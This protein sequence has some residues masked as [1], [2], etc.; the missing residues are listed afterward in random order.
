MEHENED[1]KGRHIELR[2]RYI[3]ESRA[4]EV[5]REAERESEIELLIDGKSVPCIR[6]PDGSYALQEYAYDWRD[7][8]MDLAKKFIDYQ[9]TA[10]EIR[11]QA[12]P[13]EGE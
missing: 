1:Y 2:K 5:E 12:E 3:G 8:M 11:R 13:K 6:M 7:N 10:D 4:P 9:D